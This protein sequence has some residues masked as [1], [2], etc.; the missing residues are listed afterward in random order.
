MGSGKSILGLKLANYLGIPF[1]DSDLEIEKITKLS[2]AQ[3]FEKYDEYYF[4]NLEK[5]FIKNLQIKESFVLAVGGGLPCYNNLMGRLNKIGTTIFLDVSI[6]QIFQRIHKSNRP[7]I[8][9]KSESEL[10]AFIKK[11]VLKRN[12][13]YKQSQL[14]L[15]TDDNQWEKLL[16]IINHQKIH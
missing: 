7:L 16:E 11:S 10:K 8:K 1:L 6:E 3:I 4:R 2:I 15:K 9:D 14:L 12:T 13:I 5:E